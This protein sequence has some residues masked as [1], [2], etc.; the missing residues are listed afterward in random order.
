MRK[1]G[2]GI[3]RGG[4]VEFGGRIEEAGAQW[5]QARRRLGLLLGVLGGGFPGA[6]GR[7]RIA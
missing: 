4:D 3:P 1:E 5:G 2:E 7:E 6:P